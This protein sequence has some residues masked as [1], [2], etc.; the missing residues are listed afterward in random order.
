[1]RNGVAVRAA[2][3]VSFAAILKKEIEVLRLW[4]A[5]GSA[6]GTTHDSHDSIGRI[7]LVRS[8]D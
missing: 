6:S 3:D 1:M 8:D 7:V 4:H 5:H 2:G